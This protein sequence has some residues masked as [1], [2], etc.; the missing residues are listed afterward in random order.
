M[1][2]RS[3]S[4]IR[5]WRLRR[6]SILRLHLHSCSCLFWGSAFFCART[7]MWLHV[8]W[9]L[10][11]S[12]RLVSARLPGYPRLLGSNSG[13]LDGQGS[14]STKNFL[15]RRFLRISEEIE[16]WTYAISSPTRTVFFNTHFPTMSFLYILFLIHT[17]PFNCPLSGTTQV[18]RYQKGKTS[19]DFTEARDSE[20]Q[21]HQLGHMQDC[22][23][24][25]T[26]NHA[27]TPHLRYCITFILCSCAFLF[28]D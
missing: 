7:W 2:P 22:T 8:R 5:W 26:D 27:S 10:K 21:W 20:W 18:S 25:Q 3:R 4:Q 9:T 16:A 24:L 17:H 23:T 14:Q 11:P 19:L 6:C 1:W 15:P 28:A 13:H 12:T